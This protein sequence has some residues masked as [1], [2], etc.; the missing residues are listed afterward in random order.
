MNQEVTQSIVLREKKNYSKLIL[1]VIVVLSLIAVFGDL[2]GFFGFKFIV[3]SIILCVA[4]IIILWK[5][6]VVQKGNK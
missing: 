4:A 1:I 2:R 5:D 3:L 6:I